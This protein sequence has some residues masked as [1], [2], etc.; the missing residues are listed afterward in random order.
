MVT[1]Q[2]G[3]EDQTEIFQCALVLGHA[4]VPQLGSGQWTAEEVKETEYGKR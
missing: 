3:A 4:Q 1:Q 2:E